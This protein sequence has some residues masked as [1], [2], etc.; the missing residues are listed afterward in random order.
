MS[1]LFIAIILI[2]G[3]Y[4]LYSEYQ[5]G[6]CGFGMF[7]KMPS[8]LNVNYINNFAIRDSDGWGIIYNDYEG[9]LESD[10]AFMVNRIAK[11]S[12]TENAVYAL[13]ETNEEQELYAIID[14]P[15]PINNQVQYVTKENF[16]DI[17]SPQL[18]WIETGSTYCKAGTFM[19]YAVYYFYA[20]IAALSL[21]VGIKWLVSKER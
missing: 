1:K 21:L 3:G 16:A 12:Y 17:V 15:Q 19:N 6:Y 18:N 9:V 7:N 10:E 11:L 13:V 2:F 20:L 5:S 8:G 14:Q 4:C